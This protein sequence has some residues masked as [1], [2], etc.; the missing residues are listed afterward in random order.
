MPRSGGTHTPDPDE[1]FDA[2][3]LRQDGREAFMRNVVWREVRKWHRELGGRCLPSREWQ[4]RCAKAYEVFE[5]A[6]V[7][8]I[9]GVDK[10]ERTRTR[11][12]RP[13]G[14][15]GQVA[16]HDAEMGVASNGG[17]RVAFEYG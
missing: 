9:D 13:D 11:R 4:P 1:V 2:D 10:R 7:A 3:G 6:A 5:A 17:G 14:V 16:V 12:T 15:L 8:R